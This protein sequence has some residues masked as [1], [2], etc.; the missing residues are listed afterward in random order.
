MFKTIVVISKCKTTINVDKQW[1]NIMKHYNEKI[2]VNIL[3]EY[4][5]ILVNVLLILY[6]Y[7]ITLLTFI[8][9][10]MFSL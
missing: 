2:L 5:L 9:S 4:H 3:R 1:F 7:C 10:L 6:L 8:I